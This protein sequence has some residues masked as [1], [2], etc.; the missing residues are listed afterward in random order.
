M[1]TINDKQSNWTFEGS[2]KG[3]K[4]TIQAQ[5]D[6][7]EWNEPSN[8]KFGIQKVYQITLQEAVTLLQKRLMVKQQ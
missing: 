1:K 2:V 6:I 5:V 3:I 7:T 8:I 4:K